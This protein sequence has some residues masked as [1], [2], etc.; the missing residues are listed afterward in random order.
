MFQ[1]PSRIAAVVAG[2]LI[3]VPLAV[4]SSGTGHAA[5]AGV[6]SVHFAGVGDACLPEQALPCTPGH[7]T[8]QANVLQVSQRLVDGYHR[9]D[10]LSG[11]SLEA[12][13]VWL[14]AEIGAECKFMHH[15]TT[16]QINSGGGGIDDGFVLGQFHTTNGNDLGWPLNLGVPNAKVLPVKTVALNVPIDEIFDRGNMAY[17]DSAQQVLDAGEA[18][19]DRRMADGMSAAEARA[20]PYELTTVVTMTARIGCEYDDWAYG[21]YYK[22]VHTDIPLTIEY[23]PADVDAPIGQREPAAVDLQA[24][25]EVTGVGLAVVPD[26][27]NDCRLHL[28][29]TIAT[30]Q[31]MTVEYRFIDPYGQ[32]SNTYTI[33]VDGTNT[34]FFSRHVDV[35]M[36]DSPDQSGDLA[37]EVPVAGGID[38]EAWAPAGDSDQYTGTFMIETVSP[39]HESAGDGFSVAYC[40]APEIQLP[41]AGERAIDELTVAVDPTHVDPTSGTRALV[42]TGTATKRSGR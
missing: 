33:E 28:S 20:I 40:E 32:P 8:G 42:L 35:P 19:I 27:D 4:A 13:S 1:F 34:A 15:L 9:F 39:N 24:A 30:N 3:A 18:E 21:T 31:P 11:T 36:L 41:P 23:L 25:P 17:F 26:P 5:N 38:D 22:T 2:A 29:G 10:E 7:G 6:K 16:G 12:G 37:T 14:G